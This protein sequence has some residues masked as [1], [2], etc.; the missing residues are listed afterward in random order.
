[1]NTKFI[2]IL[3]FIAMLF[4]A[5]NP[6][7]EVYEQLAKAQKPYHESFSYTL[8]DN[9]YTTIKNIALAKAKNAHDSA[10]AKD[11]GSLKMFNVHIDPSLYI[12]DFLGQTFLALD[13]ASAIKVQYK[14]SYEYTLDPSQ[15]FKPSDTYTKNSSLSDSLL[16]YYPNA[17]AGDTVVA[18]Y[19][20][21][22][23]TTTSTVKKILS[24]SKDKTSWEVVPDGYVLMDEDYE[25]MGTG[26]GK[27]H[28][29]SSS[30]DPNFYIPIFLEQ[31][32]PYVKAGQ[33]Y[34]VIFNYYDGKKTNKVYNIYT[35]DG[36]K[37]Q[38]IYNKTDQYIHNGEK[39]VFDPTVHYTM[40]KDDYQID[41]NWIKNNDTLKGYIDPVYSKNTERYF[42]ASAWYGNFDMRLDKRRELD[43]NGYLK[44]LSDDQATKV[45]F[46]RLILACQLVCEAD[47]PDS[48]PFVNGVPV[49][50]EISFNTYEPERHVYMIKYL[51]TAP[52]KFQYV[53]GPTLI[54]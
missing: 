12:P 1:M 44:G 18:I 36:D 11:I 39:W 5:C 38:G 6:N 45:I 4:V 25:S 27:Y 10:I 46:H 24:L 51:C 53:S 21:N 8:T 23:G 35:F 52:G 14:Y 17:N 7:K 13:S 30:V 48:K 31:K 28:S 2:T 47:F 54:K 33:T 16:K 43:P 34:E 20:Y 19:S 26:P 40:T 29:F 37:W 3:G 49:H 32:F 22:D 15:I 41:V 42:G 50:Y 9:D